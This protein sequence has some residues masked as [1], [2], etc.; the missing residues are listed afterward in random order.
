ML[1]NIRS[2]PL[3]KSMIFPLEGQSSANQR[4]RKPLRPCYAII[5][6]SASSKLSAARL[7]LYP[8]PKVYKRATWV[9]WSECALASLWVTSLLTLNRSQ[10][11]TT[12]IPL[13]PANFLSQAFRAPSG[14]RPLSATFP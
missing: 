11:L 14:G 2:A 6:Q 10:V 8:P 5:N 7:P 1:R 13:R 9:V 12:A 3:R 4:P